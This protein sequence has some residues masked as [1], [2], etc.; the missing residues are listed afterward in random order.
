ME[1]AK[2]PSLL[3]AN[4]KLI[5]I[6][7][8]LILTAVCVVLKVF[9][10]KPLQSPSYK[11]FYYWKFNFQNVLLCGPSSMNALSLLVD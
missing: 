11:K 4:V 5:V 1:L 6:F 2:T 8:F 10:L 3:K 7:N 9:R